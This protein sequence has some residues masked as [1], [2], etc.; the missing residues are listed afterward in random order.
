MQFTKHVLYL[1]ERKTKEGNKYTH[2][3]GQYHPPVPLYPLFQDQ[4][5]RRLPNKKLKLK[6]LYI[7]IDA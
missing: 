4:M 1:S 5:K 7:T 6:I 3:I 2:L